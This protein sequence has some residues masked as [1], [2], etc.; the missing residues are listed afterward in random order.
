MHL[1]G[2]QALLVLEQPVAAQQASLACT[3]YVILTAL[4][5]QAKSN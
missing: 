5:I 2:G 4:P 3:Q 1:T